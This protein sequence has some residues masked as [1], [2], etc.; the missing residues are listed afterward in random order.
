MLG[1]LPCYA[2]ASPNKAAEELSQLKMFVILS[3]DTATLQVEP[4]K[5]LVQLVKLGFLPTD[6]VVSQRTASKSPDD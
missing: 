4:A 3:I 2:A 1:F 5:E 6:A